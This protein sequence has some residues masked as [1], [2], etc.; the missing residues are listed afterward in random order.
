LLCYF[1]IERAGTAGVTLMVR[2]SDGQM[3]NGSVMRLR[4]PGAI[5]ESN[6]D[7]GDILQRF[8]TV[9]TSIGPQKI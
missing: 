7:A 5:S 8:K 4:Y 1:F 9:R 6:S 3:I 2:W